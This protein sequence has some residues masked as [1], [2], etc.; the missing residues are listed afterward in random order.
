MCAVCSAVKTLQQ[1]RALR[2]RACYVCGFFFTAAGRVIHA[3]GRCGSHV[4]KSAL[5]EQRQQRRAVTGGRRV[6]EA[7]EGARGEG[8]IALRLQRREAVTEARQGKCAG[9]RRA[10][11]QRRGV[12]ARERGRNLHPSR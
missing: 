8:A 5:L 4:C 3:A 2:R 11:R 1:K 6:V 7:F 10:V 9:G 12:K